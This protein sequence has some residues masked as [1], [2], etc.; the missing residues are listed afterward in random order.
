MISCEKM[1]ESQSWTSGYLLVRSLT[2]LAVR[3]QVTSVSMWLMTRRE[4]K[5]LIM[6]TGDTE[7]HAAACKHSQFLLR[8]APLVVEVVVLREVQWERVQVK[9]DLGVLLCTSA[10]ETLGYIRLSTRYCTTVHSSRLS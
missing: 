4:K 1:W 7:R 5:G 3:F 9:D 6:R 10:N 2:L 8:E